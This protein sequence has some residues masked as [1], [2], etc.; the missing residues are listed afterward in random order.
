MSLTGHPNPTLFQLNTR[1][2]LATPSG[3]TATLDDISDADLDNFKRLGY[4]WLYLLSVWQTGKAGQQVS[5]TH[6]AWQKEFYHT[7]PDV[8]ASDIAG[9]GFAITS[10]TVSELLGGNSALS[11][12]R[13]RMSKRGLKL[14]LDFVPN[15]VALDHP[16]LQEHPEYFVTGTEE[17]LK[18]QPANY[19]R[20][21][22][23]NGERVVAHGRDPHFSGWPDTLQL[24]YVYPALQQAMTNELLHVA[25]KCDGVRCDMAMLLVPEVFEHTWGKKP[26]AFWPRALLHVRDHRPD[27][28]AM[29]EVYWNMEHELQLQGF[30]F[31]YDKSLRDHLHNGAVRSVRQHF[32]AGLDYQM[33]SVR[34][35]E[36]HDEERAASS[37]PAGMHKAAAMLTYFSPCLRFF[38]QGQRE[39]KRKRVSPHLARASEEPVDRRLEEFYTRLLDLLRR[40]AFHT[41]RWMLLDCVPA[42][43]GNESHQTYIAFSWEGSNQERYLATV[44]YS[45]YRAQCFVKLPFSNLVNKSWRL[46][47]LFTDIHYD[48][49]GNDLATRGLFLD[50]PGWKFYLFELTRRGT[51]VRA[52]L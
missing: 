46:R 33:K 37:F 6:K 12:L 9:S 27:F 51:R 26:E 45:S 34:F 29:A 7:L 10:Y 50:E 41:G 30:D 35:L 16:W 28:V 8:R 22:T 20:L 19:I 3:R 32:Q 4:D 23:S 2:W 24:N 14:M 1:V 52:P 13:E 5:R 36:N 31:T 25:E 38:H 15:H 44:N 47:D 42:W 21:L 11:R 48:R 39:G 40:P 18:K 43:G 49:D 17:D